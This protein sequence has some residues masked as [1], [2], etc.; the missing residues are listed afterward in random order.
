MS[1]INNYNDDDLN[2]YFNDP[3]FRKKIREKKNKGSSPDSPKTYNQSFFSLTNKPPFPWKFLGKVAAYV[4]GACF[5]GG[6]ILFIY[7]YMGMPSIKE[8][9]HPKIDIASYV[10]SRDGVVIDKFFKYNRN[11]VTLDQISPNV[12]HALIATE[13]HR[14]YNHWGIDLIRTLSVP[15]HLMMGNV[16]GGSTITQQL[17]RNLYR[18]IGRDFS[19][20]RKLREM[21]TAIEIERN[22][23]KREIL[24]MYLNT[25]EF[26]NS[27]FGIESAAETHFGK[28]AKNLNI[29][30]AA[31]LIGT[32]QAVYA[33]NPRLF[34]KRSERRRNTVLYQMAK[35]GFI[36]KKEEGTLSKEPIHLDYH[37]P[38]HTGRKSRYFGEYVRQKVQ[39]WADKHGYNLY[40]DGLTIYTTLDSRM[41]KYAEQAVHEKLDSVQNLYEKEWTSPGGSYMDKYWKKFPGFLDSFIEETDA[42]KNG[43]FGYKTRKEVLDSLK[44]NQTFIDSLK[45]AVTKL[46]VGFVSLDPTNGNIL[47][48]VGGSDYGNQQ[49]DHVYQAKRQAGSTFKPFVYTVAI[50]NG[51]PPYQKYS[52][53]PT[54]FYG[55]NGK[56]WSPTD[57]ETPT[58]P[59]MVS[60][61]QGLARSMNNVTVRLLPDLAGNPG[62]NR[63]E[64]LY[65][66]AVKIVNMAHRLG[67]KSPLKAVP[68]IALGTANVSLLE[69]VSAYGTFANMGV[70]VDPMAITRIEDKEGNVLAEYQPK[71]EREAISP[72]T[73]YI[74]IDMMRGVIRGVNIGDGRYLGTGIRLRNVYG[75][76]QDIAGK[77]GTTQNS[78]DNWFIAMTPH[79]VI[80]AWVGGD[81]RRIRFPKNTIV[82][83]GAHTALPMVGE[84][85]DLCK[86]DPDVHWSYDAFEQPKGFVMPEPPSQNQINNPLKDKK[87]G[88]IGW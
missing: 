4:V 18:K 19:I 22:Y 76:T 67:I 30:E 88:K 7:L 66:A 25:V 45:H 75:V 80:G 48:W 21:L 31:D 6:I 83:Q 84:F 49:Y 58:G 41:Q 81:D 62:T 71:N 34:P 8:L 42:Y 46:E 2:R 24:E 11:Y 1:D 79:I 27:T 9:E 59:E 36:S 63:L 23:T 26:P 57:I 50:D 73:A 12:I 33:Y 55:K 77:T 16:Q 40:S 38:F 74:M 37:P 86:E 60:L 47:T 56:I 61:R 68:S 5:I 43:F 20:T 35:Y 52:K 51:Y 13:D 14:F 44:Q 54:K 78:A 69:M 17:A 72:E 28:P 15:Y 3:D 32:L 64:D 10:K 85:I 29:L 39:K 87:K 70:H 53:Y 65:P 82:G